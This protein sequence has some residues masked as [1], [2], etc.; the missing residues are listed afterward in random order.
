MKTLSVNNFSC[1][2][3]ANFEMSRLTVIIGPQASGKSVLC[4]LSFFMLDIAKFQHE[5]L[6]RGDSHE[7]CA[8]HIKHR[9]IE[10]FP[11]SAWGTKR[12]KI[13]FTAGN[14]SLTL[15]RKLQQG[16][17]ADDILVRFSTPFK[18]QYELLAEEI[19]KLTRTPNNSKNKSFSEEMEVEWKI[20]ESVNLSLKTLMGQD[21]VSYQAFV[22]AGRSF[23]TNIGKAI[24]VFE[25]ARALD[26]LVLRFGRTYTAYLERAMRTYGRKIDSASQT[27]IDAALAE[28]FG[29]KH[30]RENGVDLVTMTD[31]RKIP[32]TALSSGQ[33]ELLPLITF[34]PWLLGDGG[35]D[36]LCYIEEPEAH[37]F[38]SSQSK[39]IEALVAV[40]NISGCGLVMTTHSP[41]VLVK[42][43]N[44]L[45]AGAISRKLR[46]PGKKD[47]ETI[48]NRRAWLDVKNVSAYALRDGKLFSIIEDDGLID[49]EYLDGISEE[50]STEFSNLLGLEY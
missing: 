19:E 29:G 38:P 46:E 12:F 26:P 13:E 15:M 37:L 40:T 8:M 21:N 7:K 6:L 25:Q 30:K 43:N 28:I 34:I 2:K 32:L 48:I 44:L 49:G 24:A 9:F 16:S 18:Q 4:K 20:R 14:Y 50:M 27:A 42:I 39:L 47:L 10:W 3:S 17:V 23:F 31:G 36:R 22:P 1:I 45:K 35:N 5:S 11:I 33:Q 41:Y